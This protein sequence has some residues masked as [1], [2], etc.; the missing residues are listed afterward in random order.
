MVRV[1]NSGAHVCDVLSCH[2]SISSC[3]HCCISLSPLS[4]PLTD[5][6]QEKLLH[7][8]CVNLYSHLAST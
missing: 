4:T 3:H 6:E 8:G 5:K 2:G 7:P 1:R